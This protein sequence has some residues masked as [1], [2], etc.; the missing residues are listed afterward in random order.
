MD[1]D[2]AL[3]FVRLCGSAGLEQKK[4]GGRRK[5]STALR[6][7]ENGTTGQNIHTQGVVTCGS[8]NLSDFQND[9]R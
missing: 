9:P 2:G 4:V 1:D 6:L 7:L 5:A 8:R 3:V